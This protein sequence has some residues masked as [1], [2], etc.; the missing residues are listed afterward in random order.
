MKC[1]TCKYR[2]WSRQISD[3]P[4]CTILC[5][6]EQEFEPITNFTMLRCMSKEELALYISCNFNMPDDGFN[7]ILGGKNRY[8]WRDILDW[9]NEPA[10]YDEYD[11]IEYKKWFE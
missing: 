9:L 3:N 6:D 7:L 2:E 5:E 1:Y 8:G 11:A 4:N 10:Y